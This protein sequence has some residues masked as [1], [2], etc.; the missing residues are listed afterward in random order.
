MSKV[1]NGHLVSINYKVTNK[2]NGEVLDSSDIEN[3]PLTFLL[4]QN[5]IIPGLEKALIGKDIGNK[6]QV[7]IAPQDAYGIKNP[8]FLQ[9]VPKEQFQGIDLKKGMTLFGQSDD[10]QSVQVIV[11]EIGET[12][13]MIDYNHP[14]AGK[15]L[16]F[17]VEILSSNEPSEDEVIKYSHS[18]CGGG[19]S[20]CGG[21]H[22]Q[23]NGKCG[24]KH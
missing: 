6:F 21:E 18:C 11:D 24:C 14:L 2:E 3:K 5:Q 8:D 1:E 13:V 22:H 9:E 23:S 16:I 4:G 10:G 15:T 20:C 17:D 19:D 7:E 12:S